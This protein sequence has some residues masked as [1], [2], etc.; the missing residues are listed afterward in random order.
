MIEDIRGRAAAFG[1]DREDIVFFLGMSFIV[2]GTEEEA[3]RK[4]ADLDASASPRGYAAHI[5][6]GMGVDLAEIDLDTPIG[7]IDAVQHAGRSS[8]A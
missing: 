5:G 8:K 4:A 2:G 6:G 7:E 3:V 1:R